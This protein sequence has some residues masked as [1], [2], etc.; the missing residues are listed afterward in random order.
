M[1]DLFIPVDYFGSVVYH[2]SSLRIT[3]V[4]NTLRT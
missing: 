2:I 4:T 1:F 3:V